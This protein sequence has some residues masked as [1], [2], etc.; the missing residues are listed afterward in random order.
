[1]L[2]V[3]KEERN[4]VHQVTAL[5]PFSA[6][7]QIH[8][9]KSSRSTLDRVKNV[10]TGRVFSNWRE[11]LLGGATVLYVIKAALSFFGA[12]FLTSIFQF[13]MAAFMAIL[14]KEIADFTNLHE[15]TK[16]YRQQNMKFALSNIDM[17]NSVREFKAEIG[18]LRKEALRFEASNEE[19]AYNNQMHSQLLGNLETT[20]DELAAELRV[21][22]HSGNAVSGRI[23][24]G[25][26][27]GVERV[28][29]QKQLLTG[30]QRELQSEHSEHLDQLEKVLAQV[31]QAGDHHIHAITEANAEL[32]R[33][34]G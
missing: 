13:S 32:T 15:A 10:L 7:T 28:K 21:A 31:T 9:G 3:K 26:L 29:E 24:Q 16:S 34:S 1:M 12:S 27:E 8:Q 30:V 11:Q 20:T 6:Y 18:N 19:Y 14:R 22:M 23:L 4:M 2:L 17:R 25:F 5:Q 33:K